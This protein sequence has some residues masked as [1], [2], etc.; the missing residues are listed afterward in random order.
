MKLI[1]LTGMRF[2]RLTVIKRAY[3][4]NKRTL[5]VCRCDCGKEITVESYNLR[6]GH[7]LS[8][9]CYQKEA[10]SKSNKT[11]GLTKTR[12]YKIWVC[13]K[14]R[15]YQKSYHAF[16]HYGGRGIIVCDEWRDNFQAFYVWAM[17]NGYA[18]NLSIDRIDVNGNYEPSNCR[19]LTMSEQNKNKRVKNGYKIKGE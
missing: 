4:I 8:C 11:H 2:N 10:T 19:W 9:G 7:T 1:D 3:S 14:N 13:M 17:A 5:W 16:R 6:N 15:C 12:V 18:D